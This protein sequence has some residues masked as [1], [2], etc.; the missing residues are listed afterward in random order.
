MFLHNACNSASFVSN[1]KM[2][3]HTSNTL[4]KLG[5]QIILIICIHD[6]ININIKNNA[7]RETITK[8]LKGTAKEP[9]R[10]KS[11]SYFPKKLVLFGS[12]KAL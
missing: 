6:H 10:L 7:A 4:R 3:N 11:D 1:M 9:Y 12:M 5:K 8:S 2:K